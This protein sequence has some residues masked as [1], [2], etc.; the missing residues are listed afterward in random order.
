[1]VSLHS[2]DSDTKYPVLNWRILPSLKR[3]HRLY[4]YPNPTLIQ[5]VY[6]QTE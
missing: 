2:D 5:S 6:K 4:F 3:Y 1:M